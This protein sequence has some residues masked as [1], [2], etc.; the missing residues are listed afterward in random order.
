MYFLP[1]DKKKFTFMSIQFFFFFFQFLFYESM[2]CGKEILDNSIVSLIITNSAYFHKG[3]MRKIN[4]V[5]PANGS[6][7]IR[8]IEYRVGYVCTHRRNNRRGGF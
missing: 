2:L 8:S 6:G 7:V 1:D 3:F 5:K 4:N